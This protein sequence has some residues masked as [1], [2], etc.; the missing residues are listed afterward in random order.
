ML[1]YSW[2]IIV[3]IKHFNSVESTYTIYIYELS[4]KIW[5]KMFVYIFWNFSF[6]L[7]NLTKIARVNFFEGVEDFFSFFFFFFYP[8]L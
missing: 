4:M 7:I 1:L 2:V 3:I 5:F 8:F 6:P